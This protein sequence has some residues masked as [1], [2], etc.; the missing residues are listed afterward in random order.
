MLFNSIQY[1]VFLIAV[2][3]LTFAVRKR[4]YQ[5]ILLLLASYFFYALSGEFFLTL[6][7]FISFLTFYCGKWIY[8][9]DNLRY[10]R[11]YLAISI[12]GALGILGYFKY[13]NFAVLGLNQTMAAMNFSVALQV[14][15]IVLP[16]GISFYTFHA[17]SYVFDIYRGKMEPIDSFTEYALFVSFFP[18]LVAGPILRAK[19]FLPQLREK[20]TFTGDN[21]KCGVTRIGLGLVKKVVIADNLA[22][23]VNLVYAN[24]DVPIQN[25]NSFFIIA[26]TILFGLQI[27]FDFS[28]YTDIAIGSARI[29][30]FVFPENF[31]Q[32][33]LSSSPQDFWRRWHMTLSSYIRDY[34][35][36]P[37]GGNRKGAARTY[38]NLIIAFTL[39]GL[40]HGAAWNFVLWGA[41]HGLLLCAHRA[42][43]TPRK[44]YG[45]FSA[46]SLPPAVSTVIK[47]LVTQYFIFMGWILF[48][49]S[50]I[51][52]IWYCVTHWIFIDFST[53]IAGFTKY[54]DI[55]KLNAV[56]LGVPIIIILVLSR[57]HLTLDSIRSFARFD[58]VDYLSRL[59]IGYWGVYLIIVVLLIFCLAPSRSPEFIY[60]QF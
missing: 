16:I 36:I 27:Y 37:L 58:L 60:F 30:G 19:D 28:G 4:N 1:P 5:H 12:I 3:L 29:F 50:D 59:R 35:Y 53:L 57:K 33:Y 22:Y 20:V 40:W 25:S 47:I 9:T 15:N 18:H 56:F 48:R 31:N 13:Y 11:L 2:V 6:L 17:L 43:S 42:I 46:L 23:Y 24:P 14:Y 54:S 41:Y 52:D 44:I 26:A 21:I 55:L 10:K 39:C 49:V 7:L 45:R 8:S 51:N 38:L 34:I 32:P